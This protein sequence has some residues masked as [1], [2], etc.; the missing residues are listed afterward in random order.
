L[1][2][3]VA[4]LI[5][6]SVRSR[7]L[8]HHI[9]HINKIPST[10]PPL[11]RSKGLIVLGRRC[12][13][14]STLGGRNRIAEDLPSPSGTLWERVDRRPSPGSLAFYGLI[15]SLRRR[16]FLKENRD[17]IHIDLLPEPGGS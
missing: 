10:S 5:P 9:R 14:G 12:R 8:L 16:H 3:L 1:F 7:G 4:G 17:I 15:V 11:N 13:C 2:R 6:W